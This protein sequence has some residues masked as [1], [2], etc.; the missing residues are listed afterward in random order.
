[1][2]DPSF[3][4]QANHFCSDQHFDNLY[5]RSIQ[6]L[7]SKHWTPIGVAVLASEFLAERPGSRILDIGSGIGKFCLAGARQ[8]PDSHFYGVEQRKR[9]IQFA[10]KAQKRTGI[11]N[12]TFIHGNFTQLDFTLF[13][14]FY[15]YNS[16]YENLVDEEF[17]IDESTDYSLSLYEYYTHYL[18]NVL[19]ER[20]SGTRLVTY[21][22]F[23]E[24]IPPGYRL[25]ESPQNILLRCWIRE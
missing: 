5:P 2:N 12:A 3:K 17:H 13:D 15:F 11:E 9:L 14:H 24:V 23:R 8:Y 7:S 21:H 1:M 4:I 25:V 20:P 18:F 10:E 16:F 19:T 22:G 6:Q